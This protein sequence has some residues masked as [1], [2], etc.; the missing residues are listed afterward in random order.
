MNTTPKLDLRDQESDAA[1]KEAFINVA[2][3][4]TGIVKMTVIWP[5][6]KT[7]NFTTDRRDPYSTLSPEQ[8]E[9]RIEN[10]KK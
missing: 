8:H 4:G 5:D 2:T 1:M 7:I 3:K 10:K 9:R 6:P